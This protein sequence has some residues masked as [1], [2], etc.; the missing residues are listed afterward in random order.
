MQITDKL[1]RFQNEVFVLF[2]GFLYARLETGRI[3]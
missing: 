2:V 3:M 1:A